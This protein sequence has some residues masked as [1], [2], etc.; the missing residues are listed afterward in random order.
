VG[1]AHRALVLVRALA[2][3]ALA[4]PTQTISRACQRPST[5][6]VRHT[7]HLPHPAI[8]STTP[9]SWV[10]VR[11]RNEAQVLRMRPYRFA[12]RARCYDAKAYNDVQDSL[13]VSMPRA[14]FRTPA[15]KANGPIS[16]TRSVSSEPPTSRLPSV[17][18]P[19]PRVSSSRR[20]VSRPSS[21]TP[22]SESA[23]GCS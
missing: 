17:A 4:K 22:L 9:P 11:I 20:S 15:V 12:R 6:S 8:A 13:E 19:T 2:L 18:L 10:K 14:S 5:S 7:N 21:P 23:S 3:S 1:Q 16:T